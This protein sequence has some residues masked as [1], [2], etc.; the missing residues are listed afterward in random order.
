MTATAPKRIQRRRTKGY[1]L[2]PNTKCVTRPGKYGNPFR[3]GVVGPMGRKPIDAE[4]AVGFFTEMLRDPELRAAA[5]YPSD[6]EIRRDL[7]GFNLACF[8]PLTK[9]CHVSPLLEIANR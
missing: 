4:G 5:G 1:R 2:P 9:P 3:V 8:C 6:E 7:R